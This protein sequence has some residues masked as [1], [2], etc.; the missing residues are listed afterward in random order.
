MTSTPPMYRSFTFTRTRWLSWWTDRYF[1]YPWNRNIDIPW[2]TP[3]FF[4]KEV[5]SDVYFWV[6]VTR[7]W[8]L[9]V[10]KLDSLNTTK[11]DVWHPISKCLLYVFT[12]VDSKSQGRTIGSSRRL[13][14]VWKFN[15]QTI[16]SY[17][18]HY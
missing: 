9:D 11:F 10:L 18:N 17:S 7:V 5:S 4:W 15:V 12:Y 6:S 16:K 1:F 14:T 3:I 8:R 2:L 13:S